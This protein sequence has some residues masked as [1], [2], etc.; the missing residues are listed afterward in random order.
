MSDVLCSRDEGYAS[1]HQTVLLCLRTYTPHVA[2][3]R[4]DALYLQ[5]GIE[6]PVFVR[7]K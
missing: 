1:S 6:F 4:I 7:S 3:S 5:L 2:F